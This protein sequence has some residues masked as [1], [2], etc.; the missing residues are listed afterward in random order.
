MA[1]LD[2]EKLKFSLGFRDIKTGE[3]VG[4]RKNDKVNLINRNYLDS[5]L[6]RDSLQVLDNSGYVLQLKYPYPNKLFLNGYFVGNKGVVV[7]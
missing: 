4:F 6:I 7:Y 3:V 5:H 2:G 1:K